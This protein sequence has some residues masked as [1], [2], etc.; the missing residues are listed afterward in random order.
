[1]QEMLQKLNNKIDT[2]KAFVQLDISNIIKQALKM[3]KM[4]SKKTSQTIYS[5][6]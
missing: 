2:K 3:S 6:L 5:I 4:S 1:M